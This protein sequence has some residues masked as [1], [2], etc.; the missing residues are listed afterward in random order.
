MESREEFQS[1]QHGIGCMWAMLKLILVV[2]ML[3]FLGGVLAG[4][5][6][7]AMVG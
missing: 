4:A 3:V 1:A 7:V 6:V 5:V 2:V